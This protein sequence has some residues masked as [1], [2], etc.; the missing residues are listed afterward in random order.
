MK[1]LAAW[2]ILFLSALVMVLAVIVA[3]PLDAFFV[4]TV[5]GSYA[6]VGGI[7][8]LR[9]LDNAVGWWLLTVAALW[10]VPVIPLGVG[11]GLADRG[12]AG[13]LVQWLLW[14]PIWVPALGVMG[15]QL[16]LRFPDGQLPSP[17]W[18]W[19]SRLSLLVIAVASYALASSQPELYGGVANP[20]YQPAFESLAGVLLLAFVIMFIASAAS[21]FVRY[22]GSDSVQRMQIRWIAWAGAVFVGTWAVSLVAGLFEV[23]ASGALIPLAFIGY[24]LVPLSIGLAVMRYKLFEID[25]IISRTTSYVLVTGVL[26]AVYVGVVT[27]VSRLVPNSSSFAVAAAT[28]AAAALFRPLLSRVQ[29]VVDRRFNRSRYDAQQTVDAFAGR[30]RDEIDPDVVAVDC[31][32]VVQETVEP[33][34]VAL[35]LRPTA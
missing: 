11:E 8:V 19:F 7:V 14:W 13:T 15:T 28:L 6:A 16:L 2:A 1:R 30:L 22:R 35:W 21:I 27:T 3:E 25:R 20:T 10:A 31:L 24:A 4:F 12:Q 5:V 29:S 17:R 18:R 9:S 33:D 32:R 23:R 26:V 34:G